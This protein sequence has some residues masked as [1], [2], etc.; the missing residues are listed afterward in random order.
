MG[1]ALTLSN[2]LAVS[3]I[4][5]INFTSQ[6]G[7]VQNCIHKQMHVSPDYVGLANVYGDK[8]NIFIE[9]KCRTRHSTAASNPSFIHVTACDERFHKNILRQSEK[10][11]P[12]HQASTTGIDLG[13]I[14]IG[15]K[16]GKIIRGI[17]IFFH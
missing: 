5:H 8:R 15:D 1:N 12:L 17:W 10:L 3:T 9:V 13:L 11:Q 16:D 6:K 4:H 7:L 2:D 14:L